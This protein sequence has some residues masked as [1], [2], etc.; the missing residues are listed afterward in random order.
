MECT[1]QTEQQVADRIAMYLTIVILTGMGLVPATTSR[2]VQL[3][4]LPEMV[5]T[6]LDSRK[7]AG[8]GISS[9]QVLA[10][11]FVVCV[12]VGNVFG[13]AATLM[14]GGPGAIFWTRVMALVGMA[15]AFFETTLTQIFK[16]E[17]SDDSLRGGLAY[18][19]KRGVKSR[20]STNTLAVVTVV[21]CGIV[22]I[23]V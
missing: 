8:G 19:I 18:Y 23:S 10:I 2:D 22:I 12:G 21:T 14:F 13:A 3:R 1:A 9:F 4:L 17:H 7:D 20:T 15:I 5:C 11:S 6:V 16:V